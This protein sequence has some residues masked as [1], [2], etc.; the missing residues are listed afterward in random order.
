M[1]CS[2]KH[3]PFPQPGKAM[4]RSSSIVSAS[5]GGDAELL[6]SD[7]I[8]HYVV[9]LPPAGE[10][11]RFAPGRGFVPRSGVTLKRYFLVYSL[12]L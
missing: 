3:S 2:A 11:N 12:Q 6:R 9:P 7:L 5:F 4:I 1:F 10:G 8:H